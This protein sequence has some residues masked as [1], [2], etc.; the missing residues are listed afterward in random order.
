MK[1]KSLMTSFVIIMLLT[2][3]S[4]NNTAQTKEQK[5]LNNQEKLDY[6]L[7]LA[8]T[9]RVKLNVPGVGLVIV[10]DDILYTGGLGYSNIEQK[11]LVNENTLFAIGSTTKA[12][13]GLLAGKLVEEGKLNWND[14]IIKHLPDFKL[15]EEYVTRNATIEDALSHQTGLGRFDYIWKGKSLTKERLLDTIQYLDFSGSLREQKDYNNLMYFVAGEAMESISGLSWDE[16]INR[17]IFKPLEMNNSYTNYEGFINDK[18][19]ATG[20]DSDGI[21]S[22][23]HDNI[24]IVGASGSISSTPKDIAKWVQL[25]VNKG[26]HG[27]KPFITEETFNFLTG[28]N[29]RITNYL[30]PKTI[31]YYSIGWGGRLADGQKMF[32]HDGGIDG[33]NA[34][35]VVIPDASFGIFIMTNQRSDYKNLLAKYADE[36]FTKDIY[37]R[38]LEKEEELAAIKYYVAFSKLVKSGSESE[39]VNYY[40]SL[41]NKGFEGAMNNLGYE[42]LRNGNIKKGILILKLNVKGHPNSF[43]AFDSLAEGYYLDGNYE[44]AIKNY[45]RSLELNPENGNAKLMISKIKEVL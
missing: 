1:L 30:D 22:I 42:Y 36:I 23:P 2:N 29:K 18:V 13:T 11:T 43:N 20:Y 28:P 31:E 17:V 15:K 16:Q 8:D 3:C 40:N 41:D 44:L 35:T 27:D 21:T 24:D 7:K 39:I 25:F 26:M 12:F 10:A 4:D 37:E 45:K 34:Y 32:A 19:R 9:L 14:P 6:F 5:N 33:F 38:D